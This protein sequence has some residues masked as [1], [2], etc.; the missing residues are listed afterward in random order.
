MDDALHELSTARGDIQKLLQQRIRTPKMMIKRARKETEVVR[1]HPRAQVAQKESGINPHLRGTAGE[2]RAH[3]GA[4]GRKATRVAKATRATK[5]AKK[6][7]RQSLPRPV[8]TLPNSQ[9][10]TPQSLGPRD[11]VQQ[12]PA[13]AG[14]RAEGRGAESGR[15]LFWVSYPTRPSALALRTHL[16]PT[17]SVR[18]SC[19]R[20]RQRVRPKT[21][22]QHKLSWPGHAW[23]VC[24]SGDR[25]RRSAPRHGALTGGGTW[26]GAST[27][28]S[29]RPIRPF[30]L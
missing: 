28:H 23:H 20:D 14:G 9:V 7:R 22:H 18:I 26:G 30:P 15:T 25:R 13:T 11:P 21:I 17:E 29:P 19:A 27:A 3:Q 10:T 6:A 24:A 8:A 4:K 1:G 5:V 16:S 2:T 12:G